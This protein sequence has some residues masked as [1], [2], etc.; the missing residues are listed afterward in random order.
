MGRFEVVQVLIDENPT[1][2]SLTRQWLADRVGVS[3][4]ALQEDV[5]ARRSGSFGGRR[6]GS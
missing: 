6:G 2:E 1:E 5:S 3:L 4:R